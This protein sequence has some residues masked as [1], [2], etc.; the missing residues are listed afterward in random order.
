[1]PTTLEGIDIFL[2][3]GVSFGP[4]KAA[5]AGGVA[6]SGLEMSQNSLRLTWTR[7][8]VDQRLHAIMVNIFQASRDAAEK[9]GS[10]G[11]LV[12]GANVAGFLKV[13]R[14]MMAQGVL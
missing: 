5:N 3:A 6:T 9:Y 4:A 13:A 10:P 1:M 12:V 7:E 14:A 2:E 8:E 11:N